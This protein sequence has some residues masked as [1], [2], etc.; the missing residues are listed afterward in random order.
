MNLEI[1]NSTCSPDGSASQECL[2]INGQ[3]PGPTIIASRLDPP[4]SFV[5]KKSGLMFHLDWGDTLSVTVKNSMQ[6]NGTGIHWHGIRQLKSNGMDGT[7][8]I[9]ECK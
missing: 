7:G 4:K 1:T 5:E 8:G 9:T 3:Y 6:D 2:L